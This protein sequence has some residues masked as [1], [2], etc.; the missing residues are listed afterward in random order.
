MRGP[1]V[2]IGAPLYE[3]AHQL[4]AALDSLLAQTYED[5]ALVLIDDRS[6]DDTLAIARAAAARDPRVQVEL[7]PRRVGM[8]ENTRRAVTLPLERFPDAAYWALGSDHDVW[9]PRWLETLVAILDAEPD[10]VLAYPVTRRVDAEGAEYPRRKVAWRFDSRG[11]HDPR[12]RM[13][14]TFRGMAAGDMIYG[15]FRA[16]PLRAVGTYRGVLIPDRL[17]LAELALHGAF[18]QVPEVLWSRRYRGLAELD[19]QRRVFWPD[20]VPLHARAPWWA[21]HV[22]AF[23]WDYAVRAKGSPL[24]LGRA[25]GARLALDYLDVSVRHRLWRRARRL[26]GRGVRLRDRALGPPV[27]LALRAPAVRRLVRTRVLPALDATE[28]TLTRLLDGP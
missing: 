24:G 14:R 6:S 15:L 12:E 27:R 22:G 13:R 8:L 7:N 5:F 1:R 20:G 2:V 10:V 9:D 3:H 21:Q 25:A 11:V 17:L 23:A 26:R 28:E 19:R 16:A 18:A 4:P